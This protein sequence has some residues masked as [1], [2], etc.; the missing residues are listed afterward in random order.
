MLHSMLTGRRAVRDDIPAIREMQE[1]SIRVLGAEYYRP[2]DLNAFLDAFS[3]MDDGVVDEGHYFVLTTPGDRVVASA[4]WSQRAPGYARN[5]A[6]LDPSTATI[7]SVFVDP[8]MPRQG[9]GRRVMRMVEADA[10][11]A[12]IVWLK[13]G[14]TLSGV[15]FYRALGY[16]A[17]EHAAIPLGEHKFELVRME[18]KLPAAAPP[19]DAEEQTARS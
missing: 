8:D 9:L 6:P 13:V 7:R 14:A 17:I 10:I 15:H 12:G 2:G 16:R 3:T 4:G 11:A 1:R 18:K 19:E 5:A